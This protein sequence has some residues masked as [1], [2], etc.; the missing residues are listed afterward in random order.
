MAQ[1]ADSEATLWQQAEQLRQLRGRLRDLEQVLAVLARRQAGVLIIEPEEMACLPSGTL[2]AI[3]ARPDG[4]AVIR[5][6]P[7]FPGEPGQPGS[8]G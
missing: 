5:T 1:F 3:Y 4:A 6:E 8:G 2:I 7:G